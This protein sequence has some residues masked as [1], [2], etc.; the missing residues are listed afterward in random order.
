MKT[1]LQLTVNSTEMNLKATALNELK[2]LDY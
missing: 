1:V 2:S